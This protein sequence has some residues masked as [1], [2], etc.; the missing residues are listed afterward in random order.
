[1]L[2]VYSIPPEGYPN[3]VYLVSATDRKIAYFYRPV[4]QNVCPSHRN[5]PKGIFLDSDYYA[6]V[7]LIL[8]IFSG[9]KRIFCQGLR[10][11]EGESKRQGARAARPFLG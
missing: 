9:P 8:S 11:R 3:D 2:D 7:V 4:T 6:V 10:G 1:V 5:D